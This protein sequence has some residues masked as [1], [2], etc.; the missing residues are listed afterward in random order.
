MLAFQIFKII[1]PYIILSIA[2]ALLNHFL[3]LP[4]FSLL[5]VALS[6]TDG[7]CFSY[8]RQVLATYPSA[9]GMTISFFFTVRDTGKF[10]RKL[11]LSMT[12]IVESLRFLVGDW[13]VYHLF[14]HNFTFAVMVDGHM[15]RWRVFVVRYYHDSGHF[16]KGALMGG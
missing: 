4:P 13:T 9:A 15:C 7:E 6:L 2:T 16:S 1:A 8:E 14:L 10:D 3:H 11:P 12:F 5:L